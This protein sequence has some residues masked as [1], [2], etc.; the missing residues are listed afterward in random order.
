[1]QESRNAQVNQRLGHFFRPKMFKEM[2]GHLSP[3]GAT[4]GASLKLGKTGFAVAPN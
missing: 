4:L 3:L 2:W 1:M